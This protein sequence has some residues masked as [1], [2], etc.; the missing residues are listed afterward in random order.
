MMVPINY[1]AVLVSAI[2]MFLLG[3]AWYGPLFGKK[4]TTLM[5]WSPDEIARRMAEGGRSKMMRNFGFIAV[6]SLIMAFV[7]DHALIY[8]DAYMQWSG[9]TSGL[10]VGFLNWLG[11]IAPVTMGS[12]LWDGKSWSLWMLNAGYYLVGLCL[13]G[14]ILAAWM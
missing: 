1:L 11:F 12:V 4:W 3:W 10:A 8:A 2:V 13:M 6:G 5:G 9:I 14:M 7:L